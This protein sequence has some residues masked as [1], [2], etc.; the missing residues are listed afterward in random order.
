MKSIIINNGLKSVATIWVVPTELG[1]LDAIS[2]NSK[3]KIP[4]FNHLKT[5]TSTITQD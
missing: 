1:S 5:K 4:N 2:K 3:F